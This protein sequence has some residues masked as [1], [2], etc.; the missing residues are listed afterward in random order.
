M[1]DQNVGP[2][3]LSSQFG[4]EKISTINSSVQRTTYTG[5]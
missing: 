3:I 1:W 5:L 4:T 2:E